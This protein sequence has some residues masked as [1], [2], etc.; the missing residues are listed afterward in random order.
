MRS[1]STRC[2]LYN[3]NSLHPQ[4]RLIQTFPREVAPAPR[5]GGW[6]AIP[7][8]HQVRQGGQVPSRAYQLGAKVIRNVG[9][10]LPFHICSQIG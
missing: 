4:P 2:K 9:A 6:G 5:L 3:Y 7:S 1:S 8:T 10:P